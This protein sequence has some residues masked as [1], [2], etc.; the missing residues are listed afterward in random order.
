VSN[1]YEFELIGKDKTGAAFKSANSNVNKFEKQVKRAGAALIAA[2]S[3]GTIVR[4][5]DSY[6]LLQNQIKTVT[7]SQ[8]ELF[9]TTNK[10]ARLSQETRSQLASTTQLYTKLSRATE[11]LN[12][13]ESELFTITEVINKAFQ[14]QGAT[15]A[16]AAGAT[17]Q[18]SQALASGVLR[19][20]EFNSVSEQGTEILR[21]IG[22]ELGKN[23]GELR[24]MSKQGLIT[25]DIVVASL[26]NQADSIRSVYS[27]TEATIS[28][29]WQAFADSAVIAIG[30][31]DQEIGTSSTLQ[32]YLVTL[33]TQIQVLT[34]TATDIEVT[35]N[36]I[37]LLSVAM[38]RLALLV[39]PTSMI[40]AFSGEIAELRSQIEFLE[41]NPASTIEDI[42]NGFFEP[43]SNMSGATSLDSILEGVFSPL[44]QTAGG[45]G[46]AEAKA[47]AE[48]TIST[49]KSE[50]DDQ[51]DTF[52]LSAQVKTA[53]NNFWK[54]FEE[55]GFN[56]IDIVIDR[57]RLDR[58]SEGI[59]KETDLIKREVALQKAVMEGA[60]S[61]QESSIFASYFSR[62][63]SI[64]DNYDEQ[65]VLARGNSDEV[66]RIEQ[67]YADAKQILTDKLNLSI[68]SSNE[69]A[70]ENE[71]RIQKNAK[72]SFIA[73]QNELAAENNPAEL[74]RQQMQARLDVIREYYG[75]EN[76]EA[77]KATQAGIAALESYKQAITGDDLFGTLSESL[78]GLKDQISGTLG[79][80]ALGM[81]DG[82][83]AAKALGRTIVT[84]LTGSMINYGIEQVI[85]YATGATAATAAEGV[86]ALAV[87][88]GIAT[89]TIA[90]TAA[91][92]VLTTAGVASG[93]A[94]AAAMAPAAAATSVATAGAAP[95]A[96]TPIALGTIGAIIAAIVG[97]AAIAGS[98]EGGG[99]I[100][101]GPRSGGLDNRGG[102]LAMVH[103]NESIIDHNIGNK[104]GNSQPMQATMN[105]NL[106][107]NANDDVIA[108]LDRQRKKFG[109]MVQ[110]VMKTP[111]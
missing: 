47:F 89:Q 49:I 106:Y 40:R 105:V 61:E 85:A 58:L 78:G 57:G 68:K 94:I 6:V 65:I 10:L 44:S 104:S 36:K 12:V 70:A 13:S 100:P 31:I 109:R 59:L 3:V 17:L 64:K 41:K 69:A 82:E 101:N 73:L 107:G 23:V 92:G 32:S 111:F 84:Q 24:A 63:D 29:S 66:L 48:N 86:K 51:S 90:A 50:F 43:L 53:D 30:R 77:A 60:L 67:E 34:G 72:A 54:D 83:E 33:T 98:F 22:R 26:L 99:Y 87:T 93:G 56:A 71:K 19:G 38:E 21:A 102:K 28:Q 62:S 14:I 37:N 39:L 7:D 79:Q 18:L 4:Y 8:E 27:E 9:E 5:A 108:Q 15:T 103:P 80:M 11:E 42:L 95:A 35:Q 52:S 96:A 1:K 25:A 91:T 74:A 110:Q 45:V 97:G 81:T 75:L 16:E 46:K 76:A 20:Q 2:F 88:G 55:N